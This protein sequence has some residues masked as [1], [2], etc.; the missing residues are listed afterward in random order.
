[1]TRAN[2]RRSR[3]KGIKFWERDHL[4]VETYSGLMSAIHVPT[5]HTRNFA[6]NRSALW[7]ADDS[8]RRRPLLRLSASAATRTCSMVFYY[9]ALNVRPKS[10]FETRRAARLPIPWAKDRR[11]EDKRSRYAQEAVFWADILGIPGSAAGLV[12]LENIRCDGG[13]SLEYWKPSIVIV[14]DTLPADGRPPIINNFLPIDDA[15]PRRRMAPIGFKLEG[16]SC[17]RKSASRSWW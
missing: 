17:S 4:I 15:H 1:M 8:G 10:S 13:T 3:H 7:R 9:A 5:N 11:I 12:P 2:A 14:D 6:S 16:R